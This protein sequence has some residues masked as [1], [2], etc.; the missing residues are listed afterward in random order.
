[1]KYKVNPIKIGLS[2]INYTHNFGDFE[3][4]LWVKRKN[5]YTPKTHE[6]THFRFFI[7]FC[8]NLPAFFVTRKIELFIF[9]V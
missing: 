4:T 8:S 5:G 7:H 6:M 9:E 2:F 1:M 3:L